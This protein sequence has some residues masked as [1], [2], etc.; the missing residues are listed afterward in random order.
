VR[1]RNGAGGPVEDVPGGGFGLIG[2]RER[3]RTLGGRFRTEPRLDGG[4]EVEAGLPV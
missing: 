4:F 2:L 1:V 3:V